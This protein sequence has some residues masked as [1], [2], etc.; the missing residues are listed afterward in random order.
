MITGDSELTAASINDQLDVSPK[1]HLFLNFAGTDQK[2]F[3]WFDGDG[4][5]SHEFD[6]KTLA[7]FQK[8]YTLCITGNVLK[9][10]SDS[11]RPTDISHL[12]KYSTVFARVSPSQKVSQ[13]ILL[14]TIKNSIPGIYYLHFESSWR[15]SS[16]VW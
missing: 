15:K 12:I 8:E 5:K 7:S 13:N 11:A 3:A 9:T 16:Y 14:L 6:A 1:T 4:K 10:F 2:T